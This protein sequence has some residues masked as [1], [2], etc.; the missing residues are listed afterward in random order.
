MLVQRRKRWASVIP[1]LVQSIVLG[2][3]D[4]LVHSIIPCAWERG[5]QVKRGGEHQ[6]LAQ[7]CFHVG[8]S[9]TTLARHTI[10]IGSDVTVFCLIGV[11]STVSHL[12][13]KP[14]AIM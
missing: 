12:V 10:G 11:M 3:R 8:P 1:A 13:T 4:M 5:K 14:K 7:C 6:T 2:C 9:P